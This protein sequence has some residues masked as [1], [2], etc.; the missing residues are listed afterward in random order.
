MAYKK[1]V[2]AKPKAAAISFLNRDRHVADNV[3]RD[4]KKHR[5]DIICFGNAAADFLAVFPHYPKLDERA[6]AKSFTQQGGGEAATA[7]VTISRLGARVSFVGKVGDDQ[8]GIF[9]KDGLK[10]EGVDLSHLIVEKD[11]SSLFAFIAIDEKSGKRTIFWHRGTALIEAKEINK[12]FITS[13]SL[14]HLDHRNVEAATTAAGWAKKAGIPITLDLDL[15]NPELEKLV[16][17]TSVVLG[18]ETL[19]DHLSSKP[20]KAAEE[21]LKL[22]PKIAVLTFGDQGCLVKTREEEFFQPALKVKPV[23]TTGAGDVFRGAFTYGIFK[24]WPLRKTAQVAS[25]VAAIKCTKVGGR[26]GIPTLEEVSAFIRKNHP[27]SLSSL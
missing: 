15:L 19:S 2:I 12:S 11:K 18:S 4:D 9:I 10:K 24:K 16:T 17:K 8:M 1:V 25:I 26:T 27:F 20:S 13:C 21:I 6:M 14:L 23:D 5:F 22:G 3:P 7:A